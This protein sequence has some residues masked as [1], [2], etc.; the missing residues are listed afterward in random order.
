MTPAPAA[1]FKIPAES[2]QPFRGAVGR[3]RRAAAKPK[4]AG[5]AAGRVAGAGTRA[6]TRGDGEAIELGLGITVYPP[7]DEGG[8][9]RAAWHEDGERQQCESV[10]EDKLAARLEKVRQ[11]LSTGAASMTRP[12]ADL[13]AWY[14]N[15]G[16]LPAEPRW[17][18]KHADSQRRLCQRFAAPVIGAV[19]CQDITAS[20]TQKIVNAAPTAGEGAQ[21][22]RMLSAMVNVGIE[23]GYLANSR[24]AKAS[25]R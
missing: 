20:H 16:R 24:L 13:I 10:S 14:L 3:A 6:A 5:L 11:R 8:R 7:R 19:T 22:A 1:V 4:A 18:R 12:G 9:R 17:S 25:G 21:V 2:P 15:P 23:G